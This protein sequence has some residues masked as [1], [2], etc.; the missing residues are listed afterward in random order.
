VIVFTGDSA[1]SESLTELAKG[2]DLL[3]SEANSIDQR[4]QD[5]LHS[6]QC[7]Q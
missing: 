4:M 7:R 5:L 3:V 6:G 2:A 1:P